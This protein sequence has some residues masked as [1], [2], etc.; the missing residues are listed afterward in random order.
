MW[1]LRPPIL[2]IH[3]LVSEVLRAFDEDRLSKLVYDAIHDIYDVTRSFIT[4]SRNWQHRAYITSIYNRWRFER[5]SYEN[6]LDL[7]SERPKERQDPIY[8]AVYLTAILFF[9]ILDN[10]DRSPEKI[11]V[12]CKLLEELQVVLQDTKDAMWLEANPFIFS[13]L[14]LTCAAASE[15]VHQR[16]WFYYRQGPVFMALING[17]SC[18]QDALSYYTW[19]RNLSPALPSRDQLYSQH[20]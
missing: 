3:K 10:S 8:S 19:L 16:A 9:S 5:D 4:T 7:S 11:H 6:A 15:S 17:P 20:A 13:W 18:I 2:Y 1:P 14:C 12:Q